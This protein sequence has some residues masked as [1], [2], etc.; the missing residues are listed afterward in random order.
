[1]EQVDVVVVGAGFAGLAVARETAVAGLATVV[2]ERKSDPGAAP[3]TTGIIVDEARR[4]LP[5]PERLLRPLD[6]VRLVAPSQRRHL[7]LSRPGYH[8]YA[9]DTPGVLRWLAAETTV[10]GAELRTSTAFRD[11]VRRADGIELPELGL[12]T[13]LLVGADGVRSRVALRFG[14]GR[15]RR[16]LVGVEDELLLPAS[17]APRSVLCLLDPV[18]APGYLGW[19]VPGVGGVTQVGLARHACRSSNGRAR[20]D[21]ALDRLVGRLAR[22]GRVDLRGAR[23]LGRRAGLIPIDGPRRRASGPGVVLVGDAAGWVSP[24]TGGGIHTALAWG[25]RA[26]ATIADALRR[27]RETPGGARIRPAG[28][29]FVFKRVLRAAFEVLAREPLIEAAFRTPALPALARLVFFHTRGLLSPGAWRA[30]LP[31]RSGWPATG[32]TV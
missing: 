22:S 13:R 24:L 21:L 29:R 11:A 6:R 28:P 23:R 16:A 30:L 15:C 26:G 12:R 3:R 25:R 14:L 27:R 20:P 4:H 19:V 2:L 7:D 31:R 8:F 17:A 9:T 32:P 10:A 18:L 1:M 5:I